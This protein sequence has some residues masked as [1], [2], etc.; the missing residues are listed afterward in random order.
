MTIK[1]M[2]LYSAEYAQLFS[3]FLPKQIPISK[4]F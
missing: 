3:G 1:N 2:M 4:F